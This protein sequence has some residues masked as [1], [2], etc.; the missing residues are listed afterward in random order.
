MNISLKVALSKH[1][2]KSRATPLRKVFGDGYL[3]STNKV[4]KNIR[5]TLLRQGFGFTSSDFC[6]YGFMRLAALDRILAKGKLPYT[7]TVS[8]LE[9]LERERPSSFHVDELEMTHP[10]TLSHESCHCV[11]DRILRMR[12]GRLSPHAAESMRVL[13]LIVPEAFALATDTMIC[14]YTRDSIERYFYETN[15]YQTDPLI[16]LQRMRVR[17]GLDAFGFRDTY[18]ILIYAA[19]FGQFLRRRLVGKDLKD[20][21]RLAIPERGKLRPAQKE[22]MKQLVRCWLHYEKRKGFYVDTAHLYFRMVLGTKKKLPHLLDFDFVAML[23]ANPGLR[24][25]IEM[26]IGCAELGPAAL[27]SGT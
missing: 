12:A 26:M 13:R 18:R 20:F 14:G 17:D 7:D 25:A 2:A 4:Y 19:I 23:D 15:S 24:E 1:H 10:N 16:Q 11:A 8:A 3:Y 21:V 9:L 6:S 22:A 27:K 5:D